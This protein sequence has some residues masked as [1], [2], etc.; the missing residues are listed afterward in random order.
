MLWHLRSKQYQYE[1]DPC[2]H[3]A[4]PEVL[5][6]LWLPAF[7]ELLLVK[8]IVRLFSTA[9]CDPDLACRFLSL[10]RLSTI[11]ANKKKCAKQKLWKVSH[12]YD[13]SK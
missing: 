8:K 4:L 12:D 13:V 9:I 5:F 11:T 6:F 7:L 3:D 10:C 2:Y 1:S